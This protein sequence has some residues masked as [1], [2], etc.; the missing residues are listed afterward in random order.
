MQPGGGYSKSR[1]EGLKG[2]GGGKKG[3]GGGKKGHGGRGC[4]WHEG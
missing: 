3:D 4:C 1:G 2:M